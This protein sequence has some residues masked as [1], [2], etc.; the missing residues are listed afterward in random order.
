MQNDR[1]A[2]KDSI[3]RLQD[4]IKEFQRL[5]DEETAKN[6]RDKSGPRAAL[7]ARMAKLQQTIDE[8]ATQQAQYEEFRSAFDASRPDT[9]RELESAQRN[10]QQA[11]KE[12]EN[13]NGALRAANAVRGNALGAFG[14]KMGEIR[15]AVARDKGWAG[16][17]PIGP[18]GLHVKLKDS[19]WS[20]VIESSLNS[21]LNCFIITDVRDRERL[22]RIFGSA[23]RYVLHIYDDSDN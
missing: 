18:I 11:D 3:T 5:I 21:V 12:V 19:K 14:P 13:A 17:T 6:A 2:Q 23:G 10:L 16:Q 22:R 20:D 15:Q 8:F 1:R 4:E 7:Q 9:Q